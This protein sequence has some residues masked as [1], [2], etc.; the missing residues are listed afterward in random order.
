MVASPIMAHYRRSVY[1]ILDN[2][3]SVEFSFASDPRPYS[4]IASLQPSEVKRHIF[5]PNL[6]IGPF[7]FQR[8]L[9]RAIAYSDFNAVILTGDPRILSNWVVGLLARIKGIKVYFWT[10]GWHRPEKGLK[11]VLRFAF[12]R[13]ANFLLLYGE[14]GKTIGMQL[15]FPPNRMCV[16]GNSIGVPDS[17]ELDT[18]FH[19]PGKRSDVLWLGAVVRLTKAK[20]LQFLLDAVQL[21]RAAGEDAR[22]IFVGEGP[23]REYLEEKAR[24]LG[25]PLVLIGAVYGR[26]NL[27]RIYSLIDITVVPSSIGLTAIQSLTFGVPVISDDCQYS[28]MPEWEALVPGDTGEV[29]TRGSTVALAEAIR[30]LR[31]SLRASPDRVELRCRSEIQS[32]WSPESQAQ[33]ILEA[34]EK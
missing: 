6:R 26:R 10:I 2:Q 30:R 22:V 16:I 24:E 5:S 34:L 20:N 4:G 18:D 3:N 28:Q 13:V 17:L 9:A 14:L 31:D 32:N 1:A 23:E 19:L 11:R 29:Y 33:R 15:G 21:L 25:V 12:Y 27:E 7:T 8:R